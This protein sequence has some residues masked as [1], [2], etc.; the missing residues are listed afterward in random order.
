VPHNEVPDLDAVAE[1]VGLPA[2]IART[3]PDM[4]GDNRE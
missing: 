3:D 4:L 1:D 2:A